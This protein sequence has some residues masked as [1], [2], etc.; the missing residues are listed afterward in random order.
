[1]S[2]I[3][4]FEL[5]GIKNF[6][7][8]EEEE[9]I[10]GNVYYKGKKIGYYSQDAW[11][12]MDIFNIDYNLNKDL[13]KEIEDLSNNYIGGVLFKEL[14]DLYDKMYHLEDKWHYEKKGYEYLFSDLLQLNEH[15]RL[16]KKYTKKFK[17]D[18]IAIVYEDAFNMKIVKNIGQ[19]LDKLFKDKV[20]F[21]YDSLENF[22]K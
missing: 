10:Q 17:H 9:L 15:E 12:G 3:N 2:K 1:M 13:R 16:Y 7:G 18:K 19:D 6:R 22:N 5:K 4:G 8:H 20:I 11:G 21:K 14:D